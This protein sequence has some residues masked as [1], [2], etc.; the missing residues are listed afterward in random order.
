MNIDILSI[1]KETYLCQNLSLSCLLNN[2][3]DL[4]VTHNVGSSKLVFKHTDNS[5]P[6]Y[7]RELVDGEIIDKEFTEKVKC[8][9]YDFPYYT[10]T[11]PAKMVASS[12]GLF[13]VHEYTMVKEQT[14]QVVDYHAISALIREM[15]KLFSNNE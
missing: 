14:E 12:Y 4:E 13:H 3:N 2:E 1:A 7:Y 11:E 8:I 6:Y 9:S 10:V 15:I 5:K